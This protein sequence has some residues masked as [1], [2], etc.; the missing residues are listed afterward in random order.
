MVL[1]SCDDRTA[2]SDAA[3][4]VTDEPVDSAPLT[5]PLT[6]PLSSHLYSQV[7]PVSKRRIV[8]VPGQQPVIE[9]DARGAGTLHL[10]AALPGGNGIETAEVARCQVSFDD[11]TV[12]N[13]IATFELRVGQTTWSEQAVEMSARGAGRL[14]FACQN[15]SAEPVEEVIWAQPLF[16]PSATE[17]GTGAP[18]VILISLDTLRA[19][20]V[21]GF[22]APDEMTPAL[23][24]IGREGQR[25]VATTSE[26]T[27]TLPSHFSLFYS[28]L[29][30]FPPSGDETVGLA[31]V[32]SDQGFVTAGMTGGGF[33][34]AIFRFQ[35]G[36]DHYAEYLPEEGKESDI[37]LLPATLNDGLIWLDRFTNVPLFLFLHTYAVHE[38]TADQ[39]DW[40]RDRGLM[41]VF[42]PTPTQVDD[43]RIF[44]DQLV[45]QTDRLLDP[46][47]D[48][49]RRIAETR[50]LTVVIVSDHGEAFGEHDNFRHGRNGPTVTLHDEVIRVPLIVWGPGQ[51]A[52]GK[53]FDRPTMLSDIAPSILSSL[54]L[55]V[56]ESMLGESL[57]SMW[58][59][60]AEEATQRKGSVSQVDL[61]W[62]LRETERKLIVARE[63]DGSER[64][65]LYDLASD[66]GERDNLTTDDASAV[67]PIKET[68]TA[69]L[70]DFGVSAAPG[71]PSLPKCTLCGW[72]EIAPF[73]D[74]IDPPVEEISDVQA[75]KG[76][77]D[78]TRQRLKA[79]G[80][81]Q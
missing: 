71:E 38:V 45:R 12:S 68:L 44:Y 1:V 5:P 79:L 58:A 55:P 65:E 50:P 62:S 20:Y 25:Y 29:Y 35:I 13:V 43:A 26:S 7:G 48:E 64:F 39:V 4:I 33:V 9:V 23:A 40:G 34:G 10:A 47:F 14:I 42:E 32:L 3:S 28:R 72:L 69:R 51:I 70:A 19:D 54:G 17:V 15:Q 2:E 6:T 31:Q 37:D 46:F 41:G 76:I 67:A 78:A 80:Y 53:T 61:L 18:A 30:G 63:P 75:E 66:P 36:F 60:G 52:A 49:L 59:T 77:D 73:W 27:W 24:R 56:P 57:Q 81:I 21:T 16:A 22:G 8:V 11:G 74:L